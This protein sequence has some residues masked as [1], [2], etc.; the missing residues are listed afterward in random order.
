MKHKSFRN[1]ACPI[2]LS[3]EQIGE[4]W[5]MM[6]LRDAFHGLTRF[7]HFQKSLDIA[8][9]MLARRL[10]ALVK[11]GLM[12]KRRYCN[13]PPRYEYLL[14]DEGRAFRPVLV[15]LVAFGNRHL[16]PQGPAVVLADRNTGTLA[17]PVVIDRV[18]GKPVDDD[19]FIFAAGP[20][21][22]ER[23]KIR[24]QLAAGE[25]TTDE[26]I[27][28]LAELKKSSRRRARRESVS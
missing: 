26:Y 7:D 20:T 25:I 4:W 12:V 22:T 11:N 16:A 19:A 23:V 9:N 21:A 13:H 8:P 10:E 17:E 14:T 15:A 18:S 28:K 3:L 6:I 5:T 2:A 27:K 24:M 1:S